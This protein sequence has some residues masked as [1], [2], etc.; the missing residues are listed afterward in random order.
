MNNYDIIFAPIITEKSAAMADE[1]NT[2]VFDEYYKSVGKTFK[3]IIKE[4]AGHHPHSL[5]D[6]SPIVDFIEKEGL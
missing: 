6:V 3:L 5:E 2:Y 1:K 4:G